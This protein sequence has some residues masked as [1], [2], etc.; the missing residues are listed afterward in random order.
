MRAESSSTT[1]VDGDTLLRMRGLSGDV[2]I[3]Y[4]SSLEVHADRAGQEFEAAVRTA[5]VHM[6]WTTSHRMTDH[7]T[8][9]S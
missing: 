9:L 7:P 5:H 1:V 8:R 2:E 6:S 4:V 3:M